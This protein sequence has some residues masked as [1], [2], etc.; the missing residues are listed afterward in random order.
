MPF[1]IRPF[2]RFPVQCAVTYIA[3]GDTTARCDPIG[4][5]AS[6]YPFPIRPRVR[7]DRSH[8]RQDNNSRLVHRRDP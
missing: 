1:S 8:A 6:G 5:W 3:G 4:R 2:R 7:A